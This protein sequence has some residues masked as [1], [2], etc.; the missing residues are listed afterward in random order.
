MSV[1]EEVLACLEQ[2]KGAF[3]S[4]EALAQ[5]LGVSRNAV[6]KAIKA[7][8][9]QGYAIEGVTKKGYRLAQACAILSAAAVHASAYSAYASLSAKSRHASYSSPPEPS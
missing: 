3:I 6:W 1:K 5:R 9:A 2:E 7:L 4:G 8:E